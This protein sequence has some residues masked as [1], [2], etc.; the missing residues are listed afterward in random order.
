MICV[1]LG[2][3]HVDSSFSRFFEALLILILI[4]LYCLSIIGARLHASTAGPEQNPRMA[5]Q[6]PASNVQPD[7]KGQDPQRYALLFFL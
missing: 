2:C 1:F 7:D 4:L 5:L 6:I 3:G